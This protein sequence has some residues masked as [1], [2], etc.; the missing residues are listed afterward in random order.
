MKT[1]LFCFPVFA[2]L[3]FF[4]PLLSSNAQDEPVEF[5][6]PPGV[7]WNNATPDQ[8]AD[9]V[10][11]AVKANPDAASE[12]AALALQYALQTGRWPV[13]AEED[14]QNPASANG[15]VSVPTVNDIANLISDAAS[16]ANPAMAPQIQAAVSRTIATLAPAIAQTLDAGDGKRTVDPDGSSGGGDVG[17]SS[18]G[19]PPPALAPIPG[20]GGGGGGSSVAPSSN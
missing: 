11:N 2:L 13:L 8:I 9:A 1:K 18:G 5:R 20:G 15:P 14:P 4:V 10:F 7:D 17:G 3:A 19:A 6:F 16:R 12:V